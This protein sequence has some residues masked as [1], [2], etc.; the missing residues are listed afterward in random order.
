MFVKSQSKKVL[1]DINKFEVIETRM[2]HYQIIGDDKV[3]LGNYSSYAKALSVLDKIQKQISLG[4][5]SDIIAQDRRRYTS[6]VI[7]EMPQDKEV[8]KNGR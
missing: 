4:T 7:F 6:N 2:G 1:A 8:Q 5:Q 3:L